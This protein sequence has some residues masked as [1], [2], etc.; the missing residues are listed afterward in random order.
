MTKAFEAK[1]ITHLEY[2]KKKQD[3]QDDKLQRVIDNFDSHKA[4]CGK[5]FNCIEKEQSKL[6][7][8]YLGAA[9]VVGAVAGWIGGLFRFK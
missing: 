8:I 3:E 6:K 9:M 7:G 5:R 2:I 4:D 1:V